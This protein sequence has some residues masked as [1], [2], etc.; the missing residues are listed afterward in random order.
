MIERLKQTVLLQLLLLIASGLAMH[1][2]ASLWSYEPRVAL[3]FDAVSRGVAGGIVTA[4]LTMLV[5]LLLLWRLPEQHYPALRARTRRLRSRSVPVVLGSIVTTCGG[6]E[7]LLRA[8]LLGPLSRISA[9]AALAVNA[10]VTALI[11]L[12]PPRRDEWR[13]PPPGWTLALVRAVEA[14]LLG[15]LFLEHRSLTVV[16]VARATIE[17]IAALVFALIPLEPLLAERAFSWRK[18]HVIRT[19]F[20]SERSRLS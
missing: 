20:N 19:I 10:L 17:I 11:Y 16:V 4:M 18:R 2:L 14:T 6:E 7:P 3:S 15:V 13:L 9:T 8:Y 1:G 5:Q 12:E